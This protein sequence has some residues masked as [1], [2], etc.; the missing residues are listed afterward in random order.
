MIN[1]TSGIFKIGTFDVT[2]EMIIIAIQVVIII[3]ALIAYRSNYRTQMRVSLLMD[4]EANVYSKNG[5]EVYL[6]KKRKKFSNPTLVVVE[7][8]NLDALYTNYQQRHKLMLQISDTILKGLSKTE[9]IARVEFNRYMIV[10]NDRG[11]DDIKQ[12]CKE[13]E[14]RFDDLY[15]EHYGKYNFNLVFGIYENPKLENTKEVIF[16]SLAILRYSN[17]REKN[18]VYFCDEVA[19]SLQRLQHMNELKTSALE[20]RRFVPYIQP[21]VDLI[22][23]KVIG[24]EILVRWVDENQNFLYFPGEFVPLFESNGFIKLIDFE[25]LEYG[26]ALAQG[27]VQRGHRDIVISVNISKMNFDSPTFSKDVMAI[28]SKYNI[29]PKNIEIEITETIVM[30]NYQYVSNCIMDLRQLG[31]QVAMDDFGKENSSLGSLSTNPFD[32]IKMDIVFFKN[33]LST[34]KDRYI[35]QNILNMLCKLNCHI[36]CE[37]IEDKQTLDVLATLNQNV[38]IQGYCISKPIPVSSFEAFVDTT[39]DFNYPPITEK[40][41]VGTNKAIEVGATKD[42]QGQGGTSINISG[43]TTGSEFD[44]MKRQMAEMQR[45]FQK[46]LEEQKQQA[47]EQE[48]KLMKQQMELLAKQKDGNDQPKSDTRDEKIEALKREIEMMRYSQERDRYS[49]RYY[50]RPSNEDSKIN[51]LQKEIEVLKTRQQP[52]L[53]VDELIMKLSASQNSAIQSEVEKA[54]QEAKDLRDTLERERREKEEL[55]NLINELK[56]KEEEEELDEEQIRKEQEEANKKLNLDLETLSEDDK[57][58]DEEEEEEEIVKEVLEKPKY[59]LEELE[60]IIDQFKKKYDTEWNQQ[61]KAQLKDGYYEVINGLKYYQRKQKTTFPERMK[62]ATAEVKQLYNIAKNELLQYEGVTNKQLSSYDTFYIGKKQIAKLSLTKRRI[63]VFLALDCSQYSPRQFPHK[64]VSSKKVHAKT[65]FFMMIKSRLSVKRMK[66]L[67]G[68]IMVE[69][70]V[71][72][73][74]DYTAEDF[75]A[76][77]KHYKKSA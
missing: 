6:K 47:H 44:E 76:K 73:N 22:T 19:T 14:Q 34:E 38:I 61:A 28:V 58:D 9:T 52:S 1:F 35:V 64:N 68:D 16:H 50:D 24:G 12:F 25:M 31:F 8:S 10:Y 49:S 3:I 30:N 54:N 46:T 26:C 5:L 13:I 74:P 69:N 39:F 56:K 2:I 4:V 20:Q 7:I 41:I 40:V 42:A 37:G 57:D 59:S 43:I 18:M 48:M 11:R 67:I 55:E 70:H 33:K 32:T 75:A 17:V 23:G 53:N 65:P 27:L 66:S 63:R 45:M 51:E 15:F 72:I 77:F 21:K 71:K 36:V 60:A 62:D 29:T